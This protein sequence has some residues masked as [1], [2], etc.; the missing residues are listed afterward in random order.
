MSTLKIKRYIFLVVRKV[1]YF[2]LYKSFPARSRSRSFPSRAPS[3][4]PRAGGGLRYTA[5]SGR[6]ALQL[7]PRFLAGEQVKERGK[8][9]KKQT[10]ERS[11]ST[12]PSQFGYCFLDKPILP[13]ALGVLFVRCFASSLLPSLPFSL[14]SLLGGRLFHSETALLKTGARALLFPFWCFAVAK[15]SAKQKPTKSH[16]KAGPFPRTAHDRA[17]TD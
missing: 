9:Q 7:S 17:M 4:S 3:T 10:D 2:L 15:R 12:S 1:V 14:F 8:K 11:G 5:F 16:S 6:L 13:F